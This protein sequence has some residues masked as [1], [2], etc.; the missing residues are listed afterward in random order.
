MLRERDVNGNQQI[1]TDKFPLG[2]E[3]V[4]SYI[5]NLGMGAG[6]YTSKSNYTC[7]GFN[8][9]CLMEDVDALQY[10]AWGIDYVKEDACG[11]C[12]GN[13]TLSYSIMF[14][15]L[16]AAGRPMVMTVEGGPSNF[17]CSTVGG[18][19]NAKRVGHDISP[20][21]HSMKSLIDIGSGLWPFAHNGSAN[22][23]AGGW[24]NDLD[25]LEV[26]NGEFSS[27][28]LTGL[29]FSRTHFSMWCLMKAPLIIGS[30]VTSMTPE[31][32]AILTNPEAI[33][34]NQDPLGIQGRRVAI[35]TPPNTTL[36]AFDVES[37][38]ALCDASRPT[39]NWTFQNRSIPGAQALFQQS[40][41]AG[42]EAQQWVF[43]SD[44]TLKNVA[45]G[46][47]VDAPLSGC[48]T[49]PIRLQP[50]S[51]GKA[52][53]QWLLEPNGNIR[54]AAS[55]LQCLDIPY[56][57]GPAVSYCGCHVPPAT[58]QQ[59]SLVGGALLSLVQPDWCLAAAQGP[60]GGFFSTVDDTGVQ[61]CL[62]IG[63]EEGGG[64]ALPCSSVQPSPS[65]FQ[66]LPMGQ[67][68]PPGSG[69]P[70]NYT[71]FVGAQQAALGL[72]N[73]PGASGPWPHTRYLIHYGGGVAW[74]LTLPNPG[75][76]KLSDGSSVL[77]D[78]GVGGVTVGGEWC[79][80]LVTGGGLET[81][82]VPLVGGKIG[83]A[84]YNRSP[85]PAAVTAT[86]ADIGAQA[87][88]TY[89]VR[90]IWAAS[91]AGMHMDSYTDEAVPPHGVTLLVLSPST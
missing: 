17:G 70:W 21:Y 19:G 24:F 41:K 30:N 54:A 61:W 46:L 57:I 16:Q 76:I 42:D 31:T 13:D 82:A 84:L 20:T 14:S 67:A 78:D 10:A 37:V 5:H 91:D 90:D 85:A 51:A 44:G 52:T 29:V 60:Q 7:A 36:T 79:I 32:L 18:C 87:G 75:A 53:Q 6:L 73:Q 71:I 26:G 89:M 83:V 35:A 3:D 62:D 55:S 68:P 80:D 63:D 49:D 40:C 81:W 43:G 23:T 65:L 74:T 64:R 45:S 8:A 15:A 33:A 56:S 4:T 1:N 58:N 72:S 39:Q 69:E 25:M 11:S 77:N 59:W 86:W 27:N 48:S 88:Q 2:W 50:C 28:T 34:I 38:L 12:R 22:P 66:P 47:C 9:S